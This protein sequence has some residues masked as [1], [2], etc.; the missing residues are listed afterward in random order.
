ML[1]TF[2][3][4]PETQKNL[5]SLTKKV[6]GQQKEIGETSSEMSLQGLLLQMYR[7]L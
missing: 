4:T 3:Q 1:L 7:S 2:R 5:S 6:A